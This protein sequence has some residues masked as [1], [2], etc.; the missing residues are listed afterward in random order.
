MSPDE[1]NSAEDQEDSTEETKTAETAEPTPATETSETTRKQE[2]ETQQYTDLYDDDDDETKNAT[3]SGVIHLAHLL[4]SWVGVLAIL[5][6]LGALLLLI[7]GPWA[8]G[9]TPT[10]PGGGVLRPGAQIGATIDMGLQLQCSRATFPNARGQSEGRM[11]A[12]ESCPRSASILLFAFNKSNSARFLTV[13]A[14]DPEGAVLPL[15]PG[16]AGPEPIKLEKRTGIT[17]VGKEIPLQPFPLEGDYL[18]AGVFTVETPDVRA[19]VQRLEKGQH[20]GDDT[21]VVIRV[22]RIGMKSDGASTDN[23]EPLPEKKRLNRTH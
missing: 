2:D 23:D 17:A 20:I 3:L 5:L 13:L 12:L 14:K 4:R 16:P 6:G 11:S 1:H 7:T 10:S 8:V 19:L 9:P 21:V 22:L 18:V 15:L